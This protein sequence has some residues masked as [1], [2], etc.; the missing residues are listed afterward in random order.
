MQMLLKLLDANEQ[1][2]ASSYESSFSG[3]SAN[4]CWRL[5]KLLLAADLVN[6]S[7]HDKL[8][9]DT[10]V[11]TRLHSKKTYSSFSSF[12]FTYQ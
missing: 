12:S 10:K 11:Q 4:Y 7:V 5:C 3:N 6:S 1:I 8:P 9:Q 2:K